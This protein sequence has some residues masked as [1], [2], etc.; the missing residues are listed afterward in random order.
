MKDMK[1]YLSERLEL[2][3]TGQD[4]KETESVHGVLKN[5]LHSGLCLCWRE[6]CY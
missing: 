5:T 1:G 6:C 3:H 4:E 2:H